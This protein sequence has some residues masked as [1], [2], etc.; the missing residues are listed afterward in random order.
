M[1]HRGSQQHSLSDYSHVTAGS[2][3]RQHIPATLECSRCRDNPPLGHTSHFICSTKEAARIYFKRIK[4]TTF[5]SVALLLHAGR[6][7]ASVDPGKHTHT[8]SCESKLTV[9]TLAA[10]AGIFTSHCDKC[11]TGTPTPHAACIQSVPSSAR[12]APQVW[13]YSMLC[14]QTRGFAE[15]T[16]QQGEG[17]CN[18]CVAA[19]ED[20]GEGVGDYSRV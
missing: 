4:K 8:L 6:N 2:L 10:T 16:L 17:M 3:Y 13:D 15:Q 5:L 20:G 19:R 7:I 11:L 9:C 12:F 1:G 14:P 18:V